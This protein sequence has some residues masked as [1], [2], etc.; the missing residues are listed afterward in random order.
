MDEEYIL[1]LKQRINEFIWQNAPNTMT[2]KDAEKAAFAL[3][4]AIAPNPVPAYGD[5]YPDQE[6]LAGIV[7]IKPFSPAAGKCY[8]I[9]YGETMR[10]NQYLHHDGCWHSIAG[11]KGSWD[12]EQA[13]QEA[14]LSL[15]NGKK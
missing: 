10:E 2:L 6:H 15:T 1:A 7:R 14:L 8:I 4:E 13:A 3:L 12:S 11:E 5:N 9:K